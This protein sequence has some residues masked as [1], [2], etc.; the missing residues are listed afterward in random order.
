MVSARQHGTIGELWQGPYQS[1]EGS[2]DIA[3]V[4][5][6][7]DHFFSEV[8]IE[9]GKSE[10]TPPPRTA[11]ALE[12]FISYFALDTNPSDYQWLNSSNIPR[13]IGMASS[14]ADVVA[15]IY[16]LASLH[17]I[18]LSQE[19]IQDILRGIER[20]DP[21]F[22]REPGLYLSKHQ[23]FVRTWEWNPSFDVAYSILPGVTAT[24]KIDEH[25]LLNFYSTHLND[26][27]DSLKKLNEGFLT[28]DLC[29]VGAAATECSKIFQQFCQTP[30]VDTLMQAAEQLDSLGVVR[31]YTGQIAG[32]IYP[33]EGNSLDKHIPEIRNI[34]SSY[35][36][37]TLI[38]RAGY[39]TT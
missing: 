18:E 27:Q 8:H 22:C 19:H 1:E 36:G 38:N 6:P 23:R 28:K 15:T 13:S 20:S 34:F 3:I 32:L 9:F 25:T 39:G 12:K 31:A 21:V 37:P 30:L 16:A 4:A 5:L 24:E 29:L 7:C 17:R 11:R 35:N 26:Y 2:L 14:T 10:E 33:A